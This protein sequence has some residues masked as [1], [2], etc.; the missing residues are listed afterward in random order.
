MNK[1]HCLFL[2]CLLGLSPALW[3]RISYDEGTWY[4]SGSMGAAFPTV[5]SS[6]DAHTGIGWS[7][8]IYLQK[9]THNSEILS[10]AFG[11]R[12]YRQQ[13]WFPYLF[14]NANYAFVF[15]TTINGRIVQFSLPQY[16]NFAFQ[17][18]I[19]RQ[20][21]LAIAK[22]TLFDYHHLLPFVSFG[23]GV[24]LNRIQHYQEVADIG[25]YPRISPAYANHTNT[26]FS[27][28]LGVGVD[29][30]LSHR[31]WL[32]VQYQYG[33]Y[34]T[35]NSGCGATTWYCNKI[36]TPYSEKVVAG[37]FHYFFDQNTALK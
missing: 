6:F 31:F 36:K 15:P 8:D 11:Y 23:A 26:Q 35:A 2:L 30:A 32:G 29:Y 17:Y 18:D 20:T 25:I 22:G 28:S 12:W 10:G 4:A 24:T 14:L 21:V 33:H 37:T 13:R 5:G 7:D 3:G 19:Q 16:N 1:K 27:Y 9:S 34:G